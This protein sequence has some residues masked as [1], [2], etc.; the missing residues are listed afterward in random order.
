[1]KY[2]LIHDIAKKLA[3]TPIHPQWFVHKEQTKTLNFIKP[4]LIGKVLDIGCA[5][6]YLKKLVN[7]KDQYIGLDYPKTTSEMYHTV[8]TVYG[9]AHALSFSDSTVDSVALLDVLEHLHTPESCIAEIQR[10][11]KPDGFFILQVPFL[12]PIHDAPYDFHRWTEYALSQLL[13]N[14][15]FKIDSRF[16]QGSTPNTFSLLTNIGLSKITLDLIGVSKI[17]V[18]FV[19]IVLI[20]IFLINIFGFILGLFCRDTSFM[21]Y[22]YLL[23]CRKK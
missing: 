20:L 11:L 21:P 8:P 7:N 18:I 12:Y 14:N 9:D 17:F 23:I 10:A 22:G 5:D 16:S 3:L 13:E 2:S 4:Y 6:C 15:G 1:M 19:P